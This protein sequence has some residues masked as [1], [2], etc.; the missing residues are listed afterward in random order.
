MFIYFRSAQF[1]CL[2]DLDLSDTP[3]SSLASCTDTAKAG[4][5]QD[6]NGR[7]VRIL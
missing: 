5:C 2:E 1:G 7:N 4:D 6:A 3:F